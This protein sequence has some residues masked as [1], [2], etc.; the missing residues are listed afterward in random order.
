MPT[1]NFT[2]Q[3]YERNPVKD[4]Y[5]PV[6][7]I[8][9]LFGVLLFDGAI[10]GTYSSV[11]FPRILPACPS[12]VQALPYTIPVSL[13][14]FA[15]VIVLTVFW[16]LRPTPIETCDI[17]YQDD[18]A[19][20]GNL[21][22]TYT[23]SRR[24]RRDSLVVRKINAAAGIPLIGGEG[25]SMHLVGGTQA[26]MMV[27]FRGSHLVLVAGFPDPETL[28]SLCAKFDESGAVVR[29]VGP[30]WAG[31]GQSGDALEWKRP[32]IP[33]RYG[34]VVVVALAV[35]GALLYY[36]SV[37]E[38]KTTCFQ[39]VGNS[40]TVTQSCSSVL[41]ST[42]VAMFGIAVLTLAGTAVAYRRRRKNVQRE[43][44]DGR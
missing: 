44:S 15:A 33:L 1:G 42:S 30:G 37:L 6:V 18:R 41:L 7:G 8:L 16:R 3:A 26:S 36:W 40:N 11:C 24:H 5:I 19:A 31:T 28:Y 39:Y 25:W 2:A 23:N 34:V 35:I 38:A 17:S 20:G 21:T 14:L 27:W 4:V 29:R 43:A 22:L 10:G 12:W 9:Q 32:A 13:V